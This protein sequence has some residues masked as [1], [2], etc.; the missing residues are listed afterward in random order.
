MYTQR[1]FF[2]QSREIVT[3]DLIEITAILSLFYAGLKEFPVMQKIISQK[4]IA[5]KRMET[6]EATINKTYTLK[7]SM[8]K[9]KS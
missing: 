7:V 1:W 2:I 6:S 9:A 5:N 8:C 3:G 4:R